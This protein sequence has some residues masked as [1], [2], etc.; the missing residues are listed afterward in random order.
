M[1]GR[2]RADKMWPIID[3]W[4]TSGPL[5]RADSV[6]IVKSE[7]VEQTTPC[8]LS[9]DAAEDEHITRLK[10]QTPKTPTA[11]KTRDANGTELESN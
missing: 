6:G 9:F 3:L 4:R 10:Q 2:T 11:Y 5:P 1:A 8:R 7:P